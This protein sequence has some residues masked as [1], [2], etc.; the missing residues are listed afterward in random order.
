MA[1]SN[2]K[3]QELLQLLQLGQ[4]AEAPQR[5]AQAQEFRQLLALLGLAQGSQGMGL[6][7]ERLAQAGRQFETEM[8]FRTGEAERQGQQFQTGAA[9]E[10]SR[11]TRELAERQRM[12]DATLAE[13]QAAAM[14][15]AYEAETRRMQGQEQLGLQREGNTLDALRTYREAESVP[16]MSGNVMKRSV[17]SMYPVIA[18][19]ERDEREQSIS[20]EIS[21]L[22]PQL[23]LVKPEQQQLLQ[24]SVSPEAWERAMKQ[25]QQKQPPKKPYQG[26]TG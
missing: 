23:D 1:K 15:E 13:R 24:P 6:D 20:T 26:V 19:A 4:L 17:T 5:E 2:Q 14:Q 25:R 22:L 21:K 9:A 18:G 7:R 16:G 12:A 3:L 11:F 10:E 8:G